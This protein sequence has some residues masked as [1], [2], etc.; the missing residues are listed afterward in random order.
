MLIFSEILNNFN[1]E[2]NE[3][4]VAKIQQ[5]IVQEEKELS[6]QLPSLLQYN[7]KECR[8]ERKFPTYFYAFIKKAYFAHENEFR[9]VIRVPKRKSSN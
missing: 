2:G 9:F 3:E 4:I 1:P 5:M 7:G 6:R 8:F